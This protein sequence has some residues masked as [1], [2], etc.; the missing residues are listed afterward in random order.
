[1][2]RRLNLLLI[3]RVLATLVVVVGHAASF[4]GALAFT[5][6]PQAP[7]MQSMAVTVFF[8]VSGFTIAWRTHMSPGVGTAG[9]I[10]FSYDRFMRLAVP[11]VPTLLLFMI[12]ERVALPDHPYA[13]NTTFPSLVGNLV[14][15]QN[16][17]PGVGPYGLNRPLW[18]I[19]LEFWIYIAF[20]AVAFA[21]KA[22]RASIISIA[23]LAVSVALLYPFLW[24]GRGEGLPLVWLTGVAIYF[25]LNRLLAMPLALRLVAVAVFLGSCYGLATTMF[26][27]EG[28]EYSHLYNALIVSAFGSGMA[29]LTGAECHP[30]ILM[31]AKIGEKFA[32]TLYL[33][34][35]PILYLLHASGLLPQGLL[36]ASIAC[37]V[38]IGFAWAWSFPFERKYR[39]L[40]DLG[41]AMMMVLF[42]KRPVGIERS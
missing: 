30:T 12:V 21:A 17:I 29:L 1:M 33:T 36:S 22:R 42:G 23:A 32:Y 10:R 19:S 4:F 26:W 2:R 7:Y 34:H 6:W 40:R 39:Y 37:T 27:P 25:A 41:W 5:Q 11:L 16:L 13:E 15:L 28:G 8:A 3:L 14:F 35:Y 9:F 20:G 31:G 24:T 38:C 18:T